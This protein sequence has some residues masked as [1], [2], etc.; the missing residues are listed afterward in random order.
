MHDVTLRG[1]RVILEP[2]VPAMAEDLAAAIQPG[3][4]VYRWTNTNPRT[5][6]EMRAWIEAR[7]TPRPGLRNLA[8]AQRDPATGRLAGS[9]S[10]FDVD[11][12]AESA[13]IGHTWIAAPWRRTGL[14]T[15]AKLLLLTYAFETLRLKRV[16]LCTDLRNT[17]SQDAI[18]RLGAV[19][20]GVLRNFRRN[21]EGGLRDTVVYSVIAQEWPATKARLEGMLR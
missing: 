13:E 7:G 17:R 3:D 1:K 21:L 16:Q 4:D 2:L 8:F 5:S 10:L 9:T 11:E 20:E 15:E 19:R 6:E 14:N 18:A 12:K